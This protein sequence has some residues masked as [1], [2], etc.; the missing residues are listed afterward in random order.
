MDTKR[1]DNSINQR[2]PDRRESLG[3]HDRY[4]ENAFEPGS[5]RIS[6]NARNANSLGQS[7]QSGRTFPAGQ[8]IPEV[9][10]LLP[11]VVKWVFIAI[12]FIEVYYCY[13]W[14]IQPLIP[15]IQNIIENQGVPSVSYSMSGY[16]IA[17]PLGNFSVGG[18]SGDNAIILFK[19]TSIRIALFGFIFGI[20]GKAY[21]MVMIM[22]R[23]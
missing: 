7:S 10:N 13:M 15:L 2:Q 23:S 16:D 1:R 20:T 6:S 21:R 14:L 22:V 18:M 9:P 5:R 4:T 19:N 3:S 17:H 12:F 8:R 11:K